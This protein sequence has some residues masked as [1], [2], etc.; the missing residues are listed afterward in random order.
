M[1]EALKYTFPHRFTLWYFHLPFHGISPLSLREKYLRGWGKSG[2]YTIKEGYQSLKNSGNGTQQR[3]WGKVWDSFCIPKTNVFFWILTKD[4]LLTVENIRKR[5]FHRPSRFHL[6]Q[7]NDESAHHLFL[8][9]PFSKWAWSFFLDKAVQNLV[10]LEPVSIMM[11]R[12]KGCYPGQI[13]NKNI[14]GRIWDTTLKNVC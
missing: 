12:W 4:K 7:A 11:L 6:C 2:I 5:G 10:L 9:C 13:R 1:E 8:V 3:I 14:L